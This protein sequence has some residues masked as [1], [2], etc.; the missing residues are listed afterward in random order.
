M[1]ADDGTIPLLGYNIT[2]RGA[3]ATA[4]MESINW[5]VWSRELTIIQGFSQL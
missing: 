4:Q 2:M 5:P 1:E 3:S